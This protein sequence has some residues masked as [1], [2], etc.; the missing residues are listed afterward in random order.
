MTDKE[1]KVLALLQA[2]HHGT[3]DDLVEA[4]QAVYPMDPPPTFTY[5]D[6]EQVHAM[7]DSALCSL[8]RDE[9]AELRARVAELEEQ[10][11]IRWPQLRELDAARKEGQK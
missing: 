4:Y 9:N 1:L 6:T 11:S 10:Y 5:I 2:L 7:A 3:N 8:L